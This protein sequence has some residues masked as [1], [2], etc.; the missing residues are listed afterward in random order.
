M[1]RYCISIILL[2]P[3]YFK[4]LD[5]TFFQIVEV[6]SSSQTKRGKPKMDENLLVGIGLVAQE[7]FAA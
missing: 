5:V 2:S 3:R 6:I 1:V 7:T 4:N